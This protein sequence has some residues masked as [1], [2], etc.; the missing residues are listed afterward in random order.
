MDIE[1]LKNDVSECI[2]VIRHLADDCETLAAFNALSY[3]D[4]FKIAKVG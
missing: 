1:F 3:F 4:G 2:R